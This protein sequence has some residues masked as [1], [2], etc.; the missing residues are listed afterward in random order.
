[1]PDDD[2]SLAHSAHSAKP[3]SPIH[4]LE[5]VSPDHPFL[6]ELPPGSPVELDAP[7]EV[8]APTTMRLAPLSPTQRHASR[9]HPYLASLPTQGGAEHRVFEGC[10]LLHYPLCHPRRLPNRLIF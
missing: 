8:S 6:F 2:W 5:P 4:P 1:M 3:D 10:Y 7:S 9:H